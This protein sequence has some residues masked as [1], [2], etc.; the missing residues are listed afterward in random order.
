MSALVVIPALD[1]APHIA[2]VIEGLLP[3]AR[4]TGARIVVADG[5]STDGTRDIV[6]AI[7]R[8]EPTVVLLDNP[9]RQ[10]AAGINLAVARFGA[11]AEWLI[12]V[13]AHA[14]YPPDYCERLIDEARRTGAD[15]V[16]VAMRAVGAGRLQRV[17]ALA[18]NSRLGNGGAAHRNRAE[19]RWVDHGHHALMRL[20]AFRA[21]GGYDEAFSHN[22]DAELDLRL[23]AAGLR[24][25]LTAATA[26]DYFPRRTLGAL[27]RQYFA[28]GRGRARNLIKH[29][30][31]LGARQA[32]VAA[33]VPGL[34]L[35]P[36]AVAHPVFALPPAA[37]GLACLAGGLA[38][39]LRR[40]EPAA[41]AAGLVA[42][43]MHA[44]WSAGFWAEALA[45][46]ARRARPAG[47]L[48]A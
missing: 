44:A 24:I 10:Q 27:V 47:G 8:R 3:F 36:L 1:E 39:A 21:V 41:A 26:V 16:V 13:D 38:L 18:Q 15:S 40:R 45:A 37:W 29:R 48:P 25:W 28:F 20:A 4:R 35:A 14:A 17:I 23:R 46:A 42:G 6:A 30:A 19:G 34:A 12:R 32:A 5:G 43:A 7:A 33:L 2:A 11:G 31:G 9:G 22:E